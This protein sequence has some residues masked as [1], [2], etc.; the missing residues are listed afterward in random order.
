[1]FYDPDPMLE[2]IDALA[3]DEIAE[4]YDQEHP[5][6]LSGGS[7]EGEAKM[8][9]QYADVD[10]PVDVIEKAYWPA[11]LSGDYRAAA[12]V[13][14]TQDMQEK[15]R[16]REAAE[17][18]LRES[19]PVPYDGEKLRLHTKAICFVLDHETE[20]LEWIEWR[21]ENQLP[22]ESDA[23]TGGSQDPTL[24]GD[25]N[26]VLYGSDGNFQI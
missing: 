19:K 21:K 24:P 5:S 4:A 8:S 17:E 15:R 3:W 11:A 9:G 2:T 14:K 13:L 6:L 10:D 23:S 20:I 1:M 22:S 18:K 16:I 7:Q 12:V 25:S 26:S